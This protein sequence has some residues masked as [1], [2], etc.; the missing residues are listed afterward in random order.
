[1]RIANCDFAHFDPLLLVATMAAR[2]KIPPAKGPGGPS[3]RCNSFFP[4]LGL[5]HVD[6]NMADAIPIFTGDILGR[7]PHHP[8]ADHVDLGITYENAGD[9]F[10]CKLCRVLNMSRT[11][12]ELQFLSLEINRTL[13]TYMLVVG[14]L[15][16]FG[17][18]NEFQVVVIEEHARTV[19]SPQPQ[20]PPAM[21]IDPHKSHAAPEVNQ[22]QMESPDHGSPSPGRKRNV[23]KRAGVSESQVESPNDGSPSPGRKRNVAKRAGV[24]EESNPNVAKISRQ[25]EWKFSKQLKQDKKKLDKFKQPERMDLKDPEQ[26]AK[27]MKKLEQRTMENK[28]PPATVWGLTIVSGSEL[29]NRFIPLVAGNI[30]GRTPA[31]GTTPIPLHVDLGITELYIPKVLCVVTRVENNY[32]TVQVKRWE[33]RHLLKYRSGFMFSLDMDHAFVD[34]G[35]L[36]L[37]EGNI[38]KIGDH[39]FRVEKMF[40][41]QPTDSHP[42]HYHSDSTISSA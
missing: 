21:S 30:L 40:V 7:N 17:G 26:E 6:K 34:H 5:L 23:A 2:R 20:R 24:S 31:P 15:V 36:A 28:K 41:S 19:A 10:P 27:E 25:K 8:I 4:R 38:F 33:L 12:I 29:V 3:Y 22:S 42:P 9:R 39:E 35:T 18:N 32:I 16:R 37:R 11:H 13:P 1:M 14:D